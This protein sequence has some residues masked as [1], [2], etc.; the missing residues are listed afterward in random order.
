MSDNYIQYTNDILPFGIG[1]LKLLMNSCN[2]VEDCIFLDI[3]QRFEEITGLNREDV[4]GKKASEIFT[5]MKNRS[6]DWVSF[7]SDIVCS[8]K[9]QEI[10]QWIDEIARYLKITVIPSDQISFVIVIREE[11]EEFINNQDEEIPRELEGLNTVFNSTNDAVSLLEYSNGKYYYVRNNAIH[12]NYTGFRNIKGVD[13]IEV[14]GEEIGQT[15]QK[16]Y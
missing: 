16:Y 9:T 12:Q 11:N 3:N 10:T 13:L 2:K 6:F 15:L 1:Y 7:Y 14:V 5:G 4:I 8:G